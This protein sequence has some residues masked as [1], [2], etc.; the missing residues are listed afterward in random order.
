VDRGG[1]TS[2]HRK[3]VLRISVTDQGNERCLDCRSEGCKGWERK[4]DHLTAAKIIRVARVAA[5]LGT[6]S[7]T[8]SRTLAKF[9]NNTY[10]Q[11]QQFWLAF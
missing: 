7:E 2:P 9:R 8:F 11:D 5:E 1:Q 6:V 3:I 4:P 10:L